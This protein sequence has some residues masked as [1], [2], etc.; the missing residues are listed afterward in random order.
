MDS[1][2]THAEYVSIA[3]ARFTVRSRTNERGCIPLRNG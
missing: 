1:L 2:E 3:A